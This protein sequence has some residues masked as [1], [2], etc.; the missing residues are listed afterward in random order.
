[1]SSKSIRAARR[2]S[3]EVAFA[4]SPAVGTL[5]VRNSATSVRAAVSTATSRG[6]SGCQSRTSVATPC[7]AASASRS[8]ATWLETMPV[9]PK[10]HSSTGS[11]RMA[12]AP[13]LFSTS[14]E[15]TSPLYRLASNA[16]GTV[17]SDVLPSTPNWEPDLASRNGTPSNFANTL[18]RS[19]SNPLAPELGRSS[20]ASR[21][22]IGSKLMAGIGQ[23]KSIRRHR[24][25]SMLTV[26]Y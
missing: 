22:A 2:S 16:T 12:S 15:G 21:S 8:S 7:R 17:A 6:A 24:A 4:A 14:A 25:G 1:M 19:P 5:R 3:S 18:A 9:V 20:N 11:S 23:S 13:I 26:T 10:I